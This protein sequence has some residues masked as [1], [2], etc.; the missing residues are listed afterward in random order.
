MLR[1]GSAS[2]VAAEAL[3]QT[4]EVRALGLHPD[5]RNLPL[6]HLVDDRLERIVVPH[7][8]RQREAFLDRRGEFI[9]REHDAPVA[10]HC[11]HRPVRGADLGANGHR[12]G[13]AEGA[14]GARVV[15][16]ALHLHRHGKAAG[17][18]DLRGVAHDD[19]VR[20]QRRAQDSPHARV[21]PVRGR[22]S[23]RRWP[24]RMSRTR[25]SPCARREVRLAARRAQRRGRSSRG[26]GIGLDGHG[27]RIHRGQ[28]PRIDVDADDV[29]ANLELGAESG[30]P[31]RPAS[32]PAAPHRP[33]PVP[34]GSVCCRIEQ[35]SE[36]E[37][38]SGRM[39]LPALV[40]ST[41][42]PMRSAI[43]VS[44]LPRADRATADDNQG[45]LAAPG[46]PRPPRSP[47]DRASAGRGRGGSSSRRRPVPG[48]HPGAA[49]DALG[50]AGCRETPR[51]RGRS[52]P[53]SSSG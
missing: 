13:D 46:A 41:G 48:G 19:G 12:Q 5:A 22:S 1:A 25:S 29:A 23:L 44:A 21:Q 43:S 49:T 8:H 27:S 24:R 2:R 20:G 51:R 9:D 28:F 31:G 4:E 53:G 32:R 50:A 35:P 37:W 6:V 36:S 40:D 33:P 38:D 34:A 14:V 26:T 15:P 30:R 18:H 3:R 16:A 45:R 47:P 7:D 39:P 10:R 17:V 42:A 11:D 52:A